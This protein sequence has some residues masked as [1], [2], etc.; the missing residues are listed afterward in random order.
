MQKLNI[1][2]SV[3]YVRRRVGH[4]N[5]FIIYRG[6]GT[7]FRLDKYELSVRPLMYTLYIRSRA[8][9][10]MTGQSKR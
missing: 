9:I 2:E 10:I 6:I 1:N 3:S 7:T 8:F 4:V 5:I